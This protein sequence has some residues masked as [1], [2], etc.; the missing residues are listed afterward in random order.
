MKI[1]RISVY[2]LDLPIKPS[3][4]SNDRVMSYFD[5]TIVS[6]ETD[7]GLIGW[8]ESV[9]W[10]AN[11]VE[12][13]AKGVRAGVDELAPQLI[14][15]DP[16]M[17]GKINQ[18]MDTAMVGQGYVKSAVDMACWDILARSLNTPLY[19]LFGGMLTT[20]PWVIGS[21]GPVVNDELKEM[22]KKLRGE[23][24][25]VF[26]AKSSGDV[27]EDINYL[28]EIN[29]LMEH[30]ESL[31]YDGNGGWQVDQALRVANR[32]GDIDVYFEQPCATYEE[33]REVRRTTGVPMLL[34]ESALSV[35]DIIRAKS[36]GVLDALNLK[37]ARVGGLTKTKLIW[38]L[39]IALNV[40]MEL[41]DSS[42]SELSC[43]V[44][45][46]MAHATPAKCIMSTQYPKGLK[47]CK[48]DN[49]PIVKNGRV[50][51]PE[52]PGIGSTPKLDVIGDPIA[53]YE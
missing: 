13:F 38:D 24:I 12:A 25:K 22:I 34:D 32:M 11:F 53:V 5:E 48:I 10:G 19:M 36:D 31:K 37:T 9:P 21:V 3:K 33:C 46:H 27:G 35:K 49:P 2:Q 26:S 8:G 41:Q 4:I 43:A 7:T 29:E 17:I 47:L 1:K 40:K 44:S 23:G 16:R 39:C 51:A 30:G 28:R 45:A 6:I 52:G 14:G 50:Y 42:Y 15:Q 20:D 18:F